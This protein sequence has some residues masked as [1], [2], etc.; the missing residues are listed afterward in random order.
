MVGNAHP[1]VLLGPS[2]ILSEIYVKL[3]ALLAGC[4]V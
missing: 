4:G 1:T 3:E 2:H